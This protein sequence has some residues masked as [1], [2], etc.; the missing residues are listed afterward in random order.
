VTLTSFTSRDEIELQA[1][2]GHDMKIDM[3][4]FAIVCGDVAAK[5]AAILYAERSEPEA[6]AD[7]G[8]QFLCGAETE[9]WEEAQVWSLGEV[10]AKEPSLQ[11][12]LSSP[13]G[14][15]LSRPTADSV[16]AATTD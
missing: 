15:V 5:G 7:S 9:T 3:T 12:H 2:V 1:D 16:W 4:S 14:A 6:E 10:L 8:W 11:P 13:V